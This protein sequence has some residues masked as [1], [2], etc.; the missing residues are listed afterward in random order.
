M[1]GEVNLLVVQQLPHAKDTYSDV[2]LN[3]NTHYSRSGPEA[4]LSI[5]IEG[6]E[7][8]RLIFRQ[9]KTSNSTS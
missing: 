3:L 4:Q 2:G 6:L 7:V 5:S 8:P 9:W 1:Q